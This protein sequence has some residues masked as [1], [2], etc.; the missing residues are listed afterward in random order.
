MATKKNTNPQGVALAIALVVLLAAGVYNALIGG[1]KIKT[2]NSKPPSN[3]WGIYGESKTG[4]IKFVV[5]KPAHQADQ[6]VYLEAARFICAKQDKCGVMFWEAARDVPQD[7]PLTSQQ[8][9]SQMANYWKN[10]LA[11]T[12]TMVMGCRFDK[13]QCG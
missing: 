5:V 4:Y 13:T 1:D 7:L 8:L 6:S 10:K 11:N 2:E 12:E 3:R 9:D